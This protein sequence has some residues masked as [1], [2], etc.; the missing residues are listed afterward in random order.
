MPIIFNGTTITAPKFNGVT[1]S[2]VVFNNTVVFGGAE[3]AWEMKTGGFLNMTSDSA[4][5]PFRAYVENYYGGYEINTSG[6]WT[7]FDGVTGNGVGLGTYKNEGDGNG[8]VGI[9]CDFG[10]VIR[11]VTLSL[12][13]GAS[14]Y[15]TGIK[16]I[17]EG[18]AVKD[19]T[20]P[21]TGTLD[22]SGEANGYVEIDGIVI[23]S[24]TTETGKSNY[25]HV[26]NIQ[27]T[28]WYEPVYWYLKTGKHFSAKLE[29]A[30]NGTSTLTSTSSTFTPVRPTQLLLNW[31][32]HGRDWP[33]MHKIT[34]QGLTESGTW[35]NLWYGERK[36]DGSTE[37]CW[38]V[39][40]ETVSVNVSEPIKQLRSITGGR[41]WA[42]Q[43]YIDI[44]QWFQKDA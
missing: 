17:R 29:F 19:I 40:N 13:I 31:A 12:S 24:R 9:R 39:Y 30:M 21:Q 6:Y 43:Q 42:H 8:Y 34:I 15:S 41:Y 1:L 28:K 36:I 16:L 4:P 26:Y 44:V 5:S 23:Y 20:W 14:N 33:V 38:Y 35:I 3:V 11:A 37:D 22:L 2:H 7:A 10:K 25:L 27:I 32:I 18:N